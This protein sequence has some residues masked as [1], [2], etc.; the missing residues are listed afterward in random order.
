M[1]PLLFYAET[2]SIAV[3]TG[4]ELKGTWWGDFRVGAEVG[5]LTGIKDT[6]KRGLEL[7]KE[8]RELGTEF[9]LVL[10]WLSF[11]YYDKGEMEKAKV[12]A[13]LWHKFDN[14]V[15]DHWTKEWKD[16]YLTEID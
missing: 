8:D 5:G 6:Y 3:E 2:P 12:F 7:A 11:F 10:N 13:D 1:N 14:W 15:L 4:K 9:S 16:Y